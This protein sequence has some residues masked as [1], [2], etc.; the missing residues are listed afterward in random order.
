MDGIG[1]G[2]CAGPSTAFARPPTA[3]ARPY[4][5]SWSMLSTGRGSKASA[6]STSSPEPARWVW[7]RSPEARPGRRSST[8][9]GGLCRRSA[10]ALRRLAKH[11]RSC[12]SSWTGRAWHRRPAW[13]THRRHWPFSIRRMRAVWPHRPWPGLAAKGW[14]DAGAVC[15]VEVGAKEPLVPPPRFATVDERV[16][17]AARVVFLRF[18]A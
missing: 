3:S 15:V 1:V 7:R 12:S 17:G 16:Y 6:W 13:R 18:G 9:M 8:W 11:G 10:A 4:S 5:T 2:P 14:I